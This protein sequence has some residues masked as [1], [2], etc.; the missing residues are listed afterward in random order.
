MRRDDDTLDVVDSGEGGPPDVFA[1]ADPPDHPLHRKVFFPELVQQK[2]DALE[3]EVSWMVDGLLDEALAHDHTDLAAGLADRLPMQVIAEH[4][5]GFRD[6]DAALVGRWVFAGARFSGGRLRPDEMAAAGA[7]A[8]AMYPWVS[9]QL[10]AAIAE[11]RVDDVLGAT[12]G[13]VRDGVLDRDSAA[14]TLMVF[15]GAGGETT[16]SLIGNAIRVLAE[17]TALQDELRADP[18]KVPALVEEVLRFESPFRFHPR[19]AARDTEL[20]GV[21]IPER[22]LVALLWGAANRDEQEFDRPDDVVLDRPNARAHLGFGRGIHHCVGAPLARLEARVAVTRLLA[23][24]RA[25]TL[26]AGDPP[27]WT[28]NLWIRRQEFL[29]VAVET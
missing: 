28:E 21:A 5:I 8:A 20:G 27:R 6:V 15:L 4:V 2:M 24:T 7:E 14:F 17:R 10:D 9:E 1:G 22:A 12:A 25:F 11:G 23:R 29:P 19:L 18:A 26:D 3:P 16:T 13:A